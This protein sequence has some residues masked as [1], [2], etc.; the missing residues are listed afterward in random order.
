MT[1]PRMTTAT[2]LVLAAALAQ[3]GEWYGYQI[4]AATGLPSGTVSPILSR[5]ERHGWASSRWEDLDT[6][7]AGRPR[8]RYYHLTPVGAEHAKQEGRTS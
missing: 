3:P 2:R 7:A 8:R 4:T 1:G 5:L 6:A